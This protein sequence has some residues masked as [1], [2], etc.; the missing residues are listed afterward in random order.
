MCVADVNVRASLLT[1]LGSGLKFAELELSAY[2]PCNVLRWLTQDPEAMLSVL[3][4][5]FSFA[6][7]GKNI[8]W[9]IATVRYPTVG[10]EGAK[11]E[12]PLV[13]SSMYDKLI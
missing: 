3:L 9:N 11:P 6:P 10:V 8:V 5:C 2:L 7:S 4:D 13:V 12:L 1:I